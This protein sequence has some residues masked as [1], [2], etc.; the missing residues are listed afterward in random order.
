MKADLEDIP[1]CLLFNNV[2][3]DFQVA[4]I[5]FLVCDEL[6]YYILCYLNKFPILVKPS[7]AEK[8]FVAKKDPVTNL[9]KDKVD[10]DSRLYIGNIHVSITDIVL[11]SILE[12]FG[13]LETITLHRDELGNSKGFAFARS[14]LTTT[15]NANAIKINCV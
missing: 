11:K 14:S 15:L 4:F 2:V 13:Q 12:Q 1:N 9:S 5:F 3:P 10:P 6:Y 7:E 8:N